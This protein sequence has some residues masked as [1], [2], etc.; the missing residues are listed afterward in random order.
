MGEVAQVYFCV[1]SACALGS[2]KGHG[3]FTGGITAEQLNVLTGDPVENMVEGEH[4]GEGFCPTC[5]E[6]GK[7]GQG[8][9]SQGESD[10]HEFRDDKV[11]PMQDIHNKVAAEVADPE[12]DT[13]VDTAQERVE[14]LIGKRIAKTD[15]PVAALT[16]EGG[17][18]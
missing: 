15:D 2:K 5:G 9:E 4:F 18:S 12:K 7:P 16:G 11:D 6:K 8:D 1:N 17:A 13:N 3:R 14:E 10:T